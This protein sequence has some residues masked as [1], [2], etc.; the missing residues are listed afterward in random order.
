MTIE[1]EE[2]DIENLKD[3]LDSYYEML[4]KEKQHCKR[5]NKK[6][7]YNDKIEWYEGHIKYVK[8]LTKK[9]CK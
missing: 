8:K 7:Q 9:V 1:L 5:N 6:G 4:S 3:I 2:I